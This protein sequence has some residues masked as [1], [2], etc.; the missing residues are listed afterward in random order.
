[1]L[2]T[3]LA[4]KYSSPALLI[5]GTSGVLLS[6]DI[7]EASTSCVAA[8]LVPEVPMS[9]VARQ[10]CV[11]YTAGLRHGSAS[12]QSL[13]ARSPVLLYTGPLYASTGVLTARQPACT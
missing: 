13:P 3:G 12:L 5:G 11:L 2:L 1:M 4:R 7:P 8:R 9:S 10:I 6:S